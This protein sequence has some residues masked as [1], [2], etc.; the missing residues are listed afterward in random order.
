MSEYQ[1]W[2]DGEEE[3]RELRRKSEVFRENHRRKQGVDVVFDEREVQ[4]EKERRRR[5]AQLEGKR[6]VGV[7]EGDPL[8]DDV[9]PIPQDDGEG[10]LAAIAYADEYREG[11]YLYFYLIF[12]SRNPFTMYVSATCK[13]W[14]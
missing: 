12:M 4:E 9:V 14:H 13:I 7:Y 1:E 10:A 11:T 6:E 2:K 5:I 8:W 3:L